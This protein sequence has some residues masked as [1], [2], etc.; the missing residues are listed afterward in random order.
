[1]ASTSNPSSRPPATGVIVPKM[2]HPPQ[3]TKLAEIPDKD[4]ASGEAWTSEMQYVSSLAK[5]QKM[6]ATIHQLRTLVSGRLMEPIVPIVNPKVA[7]RRPLPKSPRVLSEQLSQTARASVAEV[8]EFQ[9]MWRSPEMK[10]IWDHVD[11]RIKQNGGQLLQPTG[12]W[13]RDYDVLLEE[14]EKEERAQKEQQQ[15]VKEEEERAKIQAV[16]GGWRT[17]VETFI[18]RNLPGVRV[19]AHQDQARITI[20]LVKAG[21]A[22]QLQAV[23]GDGHDMA[24]WRVQDMAAPGKPKTKLETA[25][26]ACL[27]ACPRQWDIAYLLDMIASYSDVKQTPCAK[28]GKM[29]DNAA[30]LP[31]IRRPN[32]IQSSQDQPVVWE[33]YHPA[34]IDSPPSSGPIFS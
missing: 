34:C 20:V 3:D 23:N 33:A 30:Q 14:L 29:T 19:M 15:R 2:E 21:M 5:L 16:E 27:N 24:D 31:S 6:E 28:C 26:A 11:A 13:E 1:M 7:A 17:I 10:A 8:Q 18:R 9:A 4:N 25:V 12:M 32:P 22:F